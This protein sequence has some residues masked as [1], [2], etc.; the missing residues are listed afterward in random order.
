[1]I[2]IKKQ[3]KLFVHSWKQRMPHASTKNVNVQKQVRLL[4]QDPSRKEF[5]EVVKVLRDLAVEIHNHAAR[6]EKVVEEIGQILRICN[7]V[8]KSRL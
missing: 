3:K 5:T 6:M 2:T 1:M 8:M 7:L 4:H